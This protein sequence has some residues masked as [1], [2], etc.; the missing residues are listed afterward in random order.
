MLTVSVVVPVY[1]EGRGITERLADIESVV[2]SHTHEYEVLVVDDASQDETAIAVTEYAA[3]H[4]AV[5]LLVNPENRGKGHSVKRGC[6]ASQH[7]IVVMIDADA[8]LSLASVP[9][10]LTML[11]FGG[12]DM[13]IGSKGHAASIVEY[14][15]TR[16]I[17]SWGFAKL[18]GRL[19]DL[20]VRDTQTGLKAF[21]RPV[22]DQ[23]V[24]LVETEGFA[25]DVELLLLARQH[26]FSVAEIPIDLRFQG[27]STVGWDHIGNILDETFD[28]YWRLG[29]RPVN[30]EYAIPQ[31]SWDRTA[32]PMQSRVPPIASG[33]I[34]EQ[35]LEPLTDGGAPVQSPPITDTD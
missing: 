24:T 13:V 17:L 4:P 3:S 5:S 26:G 28:I 12:Y 35:A 23:V 2:S 11:A 31:P 32:S 10:A 6:L 34:P 25:F 20:G 14:P 1:N 22:V 7:E 30:T 27:T 21:T 16:R 9:Q 15:R 8:D 33:P 18:V 19:F 29:L